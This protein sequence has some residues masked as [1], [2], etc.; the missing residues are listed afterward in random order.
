MLPDASTSSSSAVMDNMLISNSTREAY[1]EYFYILHSFAFA[2]AFAFA[3]KG[4]H[5]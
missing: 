5:V 1:S 2:F 4:S 3:L